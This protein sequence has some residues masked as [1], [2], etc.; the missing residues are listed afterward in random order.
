[1]KPNGW[2]YSGPS[3]VYR[4]LTKRMRKC[5]RERKHTIGRCKACG[6]HR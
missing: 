2:E 4:I 3:L 6:V 5:E 1:M